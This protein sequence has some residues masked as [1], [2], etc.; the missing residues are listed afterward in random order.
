MHISIGL[1]GFHFLSK[2]T[3]TS[4]ESLRIIIVMGIVKSGRLKF[5]NGTNYI[6]VLFSHVHQ[7][8]YEQKPY[9]PN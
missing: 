3:Q 5:D 6:R 4:Y 1:T 9:T 8:K 2:Y 7:I